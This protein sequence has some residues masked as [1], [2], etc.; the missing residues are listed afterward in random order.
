MDGWMMGGEDVFLE[1]R[2]MGMVETAGVDDVWKK[3][4]T[5]N[6]PTI[7]VNDDGDELRFCS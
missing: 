7:T 3:G 1:G 2:S 5:Q 4:A 6:L